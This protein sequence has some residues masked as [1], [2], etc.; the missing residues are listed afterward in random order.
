[1]AKST[2]YSWRVSE[3]VKAEL[4]EEARRLGIS[5][6]ELLQRAT[7]SWLAARKEELGDDDA[8]QRALHAAT[9]RFA[10]ALRLPHRAEQVRDVVR[11]R[12]RARRAR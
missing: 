12:L 11:A 9:R 3:E 4:E 1:M 7:R 2:V 8:Q 5:T 6:S 10:G